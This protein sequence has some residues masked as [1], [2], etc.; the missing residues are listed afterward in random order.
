MYIMLSSVIIIGI[1]VAIGW[2][3]AAAAAVIWVRLIDKNGTHKD[4]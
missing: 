4:E 2:L 1:S 3:V